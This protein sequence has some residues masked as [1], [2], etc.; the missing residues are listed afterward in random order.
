MLTD[1]DSDKLQTVPPFWQSPLH[2]SMELL[3]QLTSL[4]GLP[5]AS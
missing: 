2:E 1:I 5:A 3:E 4:R